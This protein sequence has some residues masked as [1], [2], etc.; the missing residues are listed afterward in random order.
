MDACI[1]SPGRTFMLAMVS[2]GP[3][4]ISH[5][6]EYEAL[7]FAPTSCSVPAWISV[8]SE[9]RQLLLMQPPP[10]PIQSEEDSA[11]PLVCSVALGTRQLPPIELNSRCPCSSVPWL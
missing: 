7:P 2:D 8:E 1:R 9:S 3:G 4:M 11:R 5:Q 6:A 10:I